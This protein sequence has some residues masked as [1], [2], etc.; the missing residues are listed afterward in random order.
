MIR[1]FRRFFLECP[2]LGF[3]F[4]VVATGDHALVATGRSATAAPRIPPRIVPQH[5]G[6]KAFSTAGLSQTDILWSK[7]PEHFANGATADFPAFTVFE[8]DKT[9]KGF[10]NVDEVAQWWN[11]KNVVDVAGAGI[12]GVVHAPSAG[13][14]PAYELT[15]FKLD[16][17]TSKALT[18]KFD[19]SIGLYEARKREWI[20]TQSLLVNVEPW[21]EN[22]A[23]RNQAEDF[24]GLFRD[25]LRA[26]V[27]PP[28]KLQAIRPVL[29]GGVPVP[30]GPDTAPD[31]PGGPR[32][33]D[34]PAPDPP[35]GP[36]HVDLPVP[37]PP[38]PV[39]QPQ[40]VPNSVDNN[41]FRLGSVQYSLETLFPVNFYGGGAE[42][43]RRVEAPVIDLLLQRQDV[44]EF[45]GPLLGRGV[46]EGDGR[47]AGSTPGG[48]PGG[49]RSTR[50]AVP[51]VGRTRPAVPVSVLV[52]H[53]HV[54]ILLI[55][56][57]QTK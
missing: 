45:F 24:F 49:T 11:A 9:A 28:L 21:R 5:S 13:P 20:G 46:V 26:E 53:H 38:G 50:P 47:A 27:F 22:S 25:S 17:E 36:R 1:P 48:A 6:T 39:H 33:V 57:D 42:L 18:K 12:I 4:G 34:L 32:H 51:V 31:P 3:V 40:P 37:D 54:L 15:P 10:A 23:W 7:A 2:L 55:R 8:F 14:D 35:G 16:S 44:R 41:T 52:Q 43:E 56:H 29:G 30:P 19:H